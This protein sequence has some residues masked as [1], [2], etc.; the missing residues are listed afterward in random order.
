MTGMLLAITPLMMIGVVGYIIFVGIML[1][2]VVAKEA[3][4]RISRWIGK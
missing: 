1:G 3:D 2:A 4:I